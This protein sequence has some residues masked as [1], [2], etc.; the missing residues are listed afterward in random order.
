MKIFNGTSHNICIYGDA[1]TTPIE[2]GRKLVLKSPD[3]QPLFT[4]AAGQNLNAVKKNKSLTEEKFQEFEIPLVGAVT[5]IGYDPLPEGYDLYIVSNMYRS[6]V[7]ELGGDTS[8]LAT[9]HG[10][11][12]DSEAAI[13]PC[14]CTSLAVG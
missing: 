5:F 14:G 6:A 10:V 13:K 9:V 8:R 2:N 11:V 12:Y 4:V 7:A 1:Q 3:L